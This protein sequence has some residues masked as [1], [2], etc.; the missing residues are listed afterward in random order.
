MYQKEKIEN[1]LFFFAW[2]DEILCCMP[3]FRRMMPTAMAN[4]KI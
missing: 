2:I 1:V 4:D 3:Q